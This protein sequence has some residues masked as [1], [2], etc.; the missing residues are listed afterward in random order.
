MYT[1]NKGNKN[2]RENNATGAGDN[3]GKVHFTSILPMFYVQVFF[4]CLPT[5]FRCFQRMQVVKKGKPGAGGM[6]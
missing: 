3:G 1:G 4:Q 2:R 6:A 5:I